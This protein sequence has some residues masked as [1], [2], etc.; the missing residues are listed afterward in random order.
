MKNKNNIEMKIRLKVVS[1]MDFKFLYNLLSQRKSIENISHKEMP[2]YQKHIKFVKSKPYTYWYIIL[3]NNKK[4]G[5]A[6]ISKQDEIGISFLNDYNE[7]TF[8]QSV[9]DYIIKNNPRNR[10]IVNCN[11]KNIKSIKFFKKNRFKLVQFSYELM[12]QY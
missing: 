5:S 2:T 9:L 1:K 4:I 8:R 7:D 10:Y 3:L 12:K 6:Y 11:P